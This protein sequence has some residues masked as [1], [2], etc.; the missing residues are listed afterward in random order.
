M[1][2]EHYRFWVFRIELTYNIIPQ[3]SRCSEHCNIHEKIHPYA[4]EKGKSWGKCINIHSSIKRR[5]NIFK[6]VCQGKGSL[7]NRISACFHH[8]VSAYADCVVF[9][10]FL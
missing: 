6:P 3:K 7:E 10:H 4:E 5:F 1:C 8:M 9:G 2:S